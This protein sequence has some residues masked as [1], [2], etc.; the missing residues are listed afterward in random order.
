MSLSPP[1]APLSLPHSK[2]NQPP[3]R[4]TS[5]ATIASAGAGPH[6]KQRLHPLRQTSFPNSQ[7]ADPR[8]LSAGAASA[9]SE[10]DGGSVTGSF[11]GILIDAFTPAQSSRYDFFKR[12]KLNKS[13]VRK[14]VNQTLSQ[15]VPPNVI[16]TISGYTKVFVGEL[17]EKAR[18]VQEEWAE[19][20]DR[21]AYAEYE[22]AL[23]R[24]EEEEEV[25]AKADAEATTAISTQST[26]QT[27]T[28]TNPSSDTQAPARTVELSSS[29]TET[30]LRS[31]T[32]TEP[33]ENGMVAVKEKPQAANDIKM[34][35]SIL[36][37]T[38]TATTTTITAVPLS[39]TQTQIQQNS[40]TQPRT[41]ENVHTPINSQSFATTVPN[42]TST[43][44]GSA[45]TIKSKKPRR[46]FEPPP[47]PHRGQLLP[48][49]L[50]EALR[51]YK[52]D[53][54]GGGVG[55]GAL[56]MGSTGV[57]GSFSCG[58]RGVGGRRL[59]R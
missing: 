58:V 56:S 46:P 35:D 49:H 14:I 22:A 37:Q 27:A 53:G 33:K 39:S 21:V 25:R 18:T 48:A 44:P 47:N 43:S 24:E 26:Q 52:R 13:M 38:T 23:A 7:D 41:D 1:P 20:A 12:A 40:R 19:A 57:K 51:R 55:F 31:I 28:A 16:T 5:V 34:N 4:R 32:K 8:A 10:A 9:N 54:E 29:T 17:V 6:K 11:T 3:K 42:S 59:F 45:F 30:G 50:R 36:P 2:P 15:S